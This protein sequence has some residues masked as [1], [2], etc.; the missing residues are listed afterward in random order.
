MHDDPVELDKHRGMTAQRETELRRRLQEV[1]A[2]HAAL[3]R[4]Q[5]ELEAVMNAAPSTTWTEAEVR[6]SYL[7]HL[8]AGTLEG[9]EPR[10]AALIES[11]IDDLRRLAE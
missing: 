5:E 7:L 3:E 9:R 11:V 2:D 8:F 10:R 1:A 6:A 4:R